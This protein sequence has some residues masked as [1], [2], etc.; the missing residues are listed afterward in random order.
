MT[1]PLDE[2]F[3]PFSKPTP[4]QVRKGWQQY[5]SDVSPVTELLREAGISKGEAL[6]VYNTYASMFAMQELAEAIVE[7]AKAVRD[8]INE[9]RDPP[10]PGDEWKE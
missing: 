9:D 5:L 2:L 10:V 7:L 4:E 6:I 8:R 3:E 1:S